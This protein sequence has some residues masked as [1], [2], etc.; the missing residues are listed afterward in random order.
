MQPAVRSVMV[1]DDDRHVCDLLDSVLT[2]VGY[3]ARCLYDGE[4]AWAAVQQDRPD[5]IVSDI[6]MPKL[7]GVQL[8]RRLDEADCRI[9]VILMSAGNVDGEGVARAFLRKPFDVEELLDLIASIMPEREQRRGVESVADT[10]VMSQGC[11]ETAATDQLAGSLVTSDRFLATI[12][13]SS[14]D[15]INREYR[16]PGHDGN[17]DPAPGSHEGWDHGTDRWL[18]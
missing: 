16:G 4:A 5:L 15:A 10:L 12:V 13:E 11:A 18:A 7:D 9:P 8:A 14:D 6:K 3:R 17:G 1:V 2:E